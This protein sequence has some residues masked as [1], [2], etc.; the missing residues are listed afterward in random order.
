VNGGSV[1][2][3]EENTA[4]VALAAAPGKRPRSVLLVDL[5]GHPRL[6]NRLDVY[7]PAARALVF[8]VD[9]RDGVFLPGVRATAECAPAPACAAPRPDLRRVFCGAF[10]CVWVHSAR[11]AAAERAARPR[12][13][14]LDLLSHPALARRTP[15]LLLAVNKTDKGCASTRSAAFLP[16]YLAAF[17]TQ[18]QHPT[19]D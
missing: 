8:V 10:V 1:T 14:V 5:P 17:R 6:R 11:R 4:R 7:A 16:Y 18:N 9:G 19:R 12:R 15:P 13:L 3:M 2:S